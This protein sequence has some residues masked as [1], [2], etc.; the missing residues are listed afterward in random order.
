M[1][2]TLMTIAVAFASISLASACAYTA[3][4]GGSWSPWTYA[5]NERESSY[6]CGT[7]YDV[8]NATYCTTFTQTPTNRIE[9]NDPNYGWMPL[10][11][12]DSGSCTDHGTAV[13][14]IY[15]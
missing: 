4:G 10:P 5:G 7:C 9:Y 1:K 3:G 12:G 14:Q 6:T 13:C 8:L 11:G 15:G 2:T